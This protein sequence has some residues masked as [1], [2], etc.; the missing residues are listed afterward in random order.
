MTT[1]TCVFCTK[2]RQ[3][4]DE[5][6]TVEYLGLRVCTFAPLNPVT[7]GHMLFVPMLHVERANQANVVLGYT[8]EIAAGYG[9][10][11]DFNLIQS[12]GPSAT[13]TIPHLHVHYVPRHEGDGLSLPWTTH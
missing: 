3:G 11:R 9:D 12:N 1:N 13:Q 4:Y 8:M 7:E 6:G 10:D 2:I 5:H